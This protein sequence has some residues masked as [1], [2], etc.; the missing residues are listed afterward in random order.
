MSIDIN[1]IIDDWISLTLSIVGILISL[2]GLI[3]AWKA[4]RAAKALRTP[5]VYLGSDTIPG[6]G[7]LDTK[8]FVE[9]RSANRFKILGVLTEGEILIEPMRSPPSDLQHQ[10]DRPDFSLDQFAY[11]KITWEYPVRIGGARDTKIDARI[12]EIKDGYQ[13]V[14][15]QRTM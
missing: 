9:N 6:K 12:D 3:Y 5:L 4:H 7:W 8:L 10:P 11:P 14:L 15:F 2:A 13:I 1:L